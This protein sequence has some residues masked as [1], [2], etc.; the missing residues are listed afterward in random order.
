MNYGIDEVQLNNNLEKIKF[1][2]R[3]EIQ[4]FLEIDDLLLNINNNYKTDNINRLS[5]LEL[6]IS[7]KLKKIINSHDIEIMLIHKRIED[8]MK[9]AKEVANI[10][11]NSGD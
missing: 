9:T 1:Y 11:S 7:N 3:E 6:E 5:E 4:N 2:K 10:L 8:Y